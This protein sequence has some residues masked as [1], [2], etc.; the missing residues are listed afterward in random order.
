MCSFFDEEASDHQSVH[1]GTEECSYRERDPS[2]VVNRE[3]IREN[4]SLWQAYLTANLQLT[5]IA[6]KLDASD[7]QGGT[8]N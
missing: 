3:R 1:A 6:S 4:I 8:G 2:S 7:W 5:Q